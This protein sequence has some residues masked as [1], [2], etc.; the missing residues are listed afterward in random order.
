MA[1]VGTMSDGVPLVNYTCWYLLVI[2]QSMRIWTIDQDK[3]YIITYVGGV[4][5]DL[6]LP[7]F[8]KMINSFKI[9]S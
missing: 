3:I 5:Y 9:P 7:I 1:G 2:V 6:R 8:E 4:K